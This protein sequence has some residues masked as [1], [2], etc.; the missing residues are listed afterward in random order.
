MKDKKKVS[1]IKFD[2][3][4]AWEFMFNADN[5]HKNSIP[6]ENFISFF[7]DVSTCVDCDNEFNAILKFWYNNFINL[8]V[9]PISNGK[10]E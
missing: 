7:I 10:N 5:I 8:I 4:N 9:E 2:Y 6:R 3:S 1:E